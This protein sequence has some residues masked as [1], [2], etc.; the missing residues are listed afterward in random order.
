MLLLYRSKDRY[1]VCWRPFPAPGCTG[2][3]NYHRCVLYHRCGSRKTTFSYKLWGI[4][5][6]KTWN[7]RRNDWHRFPNTTLSRPTPCS[8]ANTSKRSNQMYRYRWSGS[9]LCQ[10]IHYRRRETEGTRQYHRRWCIVFMTATV[11]FSQD[12]LI[13]S[14]NRSHFSF[15]DIN[16]KI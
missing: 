14:Q 4:R 15:W 3:R 11:K 6:H 12:I 2:C 10:P 9:I 5:E 8:D 7:H 1:T 13:F 16:A